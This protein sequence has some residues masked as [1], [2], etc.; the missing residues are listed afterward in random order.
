MQS[1]ME[2]LAQEEERHAVHVEVVAAP[3]AT[4]KS[5]ISRNREEDDEPDGKDYLHGMVRRRHPESQ[6]H[7]GDVDQD[8]HPQV[9]AAPADDAEPRSEFC[10]ICGRF[11]SQLRL[12]L[13]VAYQLGQRPGRPFA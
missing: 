9:P 6:P 10:G 8:Y 11:L 2:T 4:G 7:G 12:L 1:A 5:R 13:S 3:G